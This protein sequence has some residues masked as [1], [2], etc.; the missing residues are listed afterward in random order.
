MDYNLRVLIWN[1]RGLNARARCLA[2]RLLLATTGVSIVCFQETKVEFLCSSIVLEVLGLEFDD[3]TYLP[4]TGTRGGI[5]L[6]WKS[7]EVSI[8]DPLFT[9]HAIT[10]K[11][12]TASRTSH[13]WW[14][15][16]VYG[17]QEDVEKIAFIQELRDIR[18]DCDGPWML[19]DDFNMIT[20]AADKNNGL[21]DQRMTGHFR[22]VI[23]DLALKEVYLNGHLYTWSNG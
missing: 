18:A 17:P 15:T 7:R 6:A 9:T 13:P 21:L 5:L 14:I 12:S 2:I 3:Y 20:S 10:T 1:V 22:R 11:V 4:A 19:R 23:N 16:V 8:T